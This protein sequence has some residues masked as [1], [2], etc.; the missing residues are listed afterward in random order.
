MWTST[1][2]LDPRRVFVT[3]F[4][5]LFWRNACFSSFAPLQ[6]E[7]LPRQSLPSSTWVRVR[8][9]L[10]GISGSDLHLIST[11]GDL[12]TAPAAIHYRGR[13]YPG[14]EVVGDVIEIGDDVQH[15]RIGDRVAL[16]Y[17]PNCLSSG[18]QPPCHSCASGNYDLCACGHLSNP[19][20]IGGGW[21]E[22]MLLHEQQLF[23]LPSIISDEQ[24]VLLEPT[25]VAVHAVLR[26][27]PQDGDRILIIGAGTIGL[28]VL[29][30]VR[31]LTPSVEVS[32]LARHS[33]QV[34]QA[35]RMGASH[36]IYPQD[37][38]IG[39]QRVTNA[40]RHRGLL[41]NQMLLGGY[42]VI[43]D[44]VGQKNS[45]HHAL[46]WTRASG[47]VVLV[48]TS[49][50]LMNIDLTPIWYQ[51][52]NLVGTMGHGMEQWPIGTNRHRPTFDIAAEL[53]ERRLLQPEHLITHRFA[54]NNY[55]Y[56]L[57][58]AANK[59]YSRAIKVVFDYA[60]QP[61]SVVPNV[62]ASAQ[63]RRSATVRSVPPHVSQPLPDAHIAEPVPLQ[64]GSQST[65]HPSPP[66][67]L[68]HEDVSFPDAPLDNMDDQDEITAVIPTVRKFVKQTAANEVAEVE[69]S[70]EV[71]YEQIILSEQAIESPIAPTE[72][73]SLTDDTNEST[74]PTNL[75]AESA[76]LTDLSAEPPALLI[77]LTTT[78]PA[79]L[80]DLSAESAPLADTTAEP[81]SL[82]LSAESAPLADTTAEPALP[83][84]DVSEPSLE[85]IYV[86]IEP[87][88]AVD[89]P[90]EATVPVEVPDENTEPTTQETTAD[91]SL[92]LP[93]QEITAT[94][95]PP[96]VLPSKKEP[97]TAR[98]QQRSS[99]RG[100]RRTK[101]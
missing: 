96:E 7:N 13:S 39:I 55:Q 2:D 68:T 33:F 72:S 6:V 18:I 97:S 82:D 71:T 81:T 40:Q 76:P 22:E 4:L 88:M 23:V 28:L 57:M 80:T 12:R 3:Q 94:T 83:T 9:R 42:D 20:S 32:V 56:A 21:S 38:Y 44:T 1:L 41:G 46:R 36:I 93:T 75:S 67:T 62:R 73:A 90:T 26:R 34:E 70:F 89:E 86:M 43:Y 17:G 63:Q 59:K 87:L 51:E 84:D 53:I 15:V 98:K 95:E 61:A 25:A 45:L 24:A 101:P 11:D 77:D 78:E 66:F 47:T 8:N 69:R 5:R 91:A 52:V 58:T 79:L 74:I 16:Q 99:T 85:D 30:I 49:L 10:A 60:L 29:Q 31:A 48:G 100:K 37:S 54:L 19:Q 64:L 50:H 92:P 27:L 14:H 65:E 35:T